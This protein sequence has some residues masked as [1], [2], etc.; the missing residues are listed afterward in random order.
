MEYI[1]L[2]ILVPKKDINLPD[3]DITVFPEV[4][5]E[6][7]D[8]HIDAGPPEV[9]GLDYDIDSWDDEAIDQL[10]RERWEEG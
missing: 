1:S 9:I 6:P 3:V 2:K 10:A 7:L 4:A 5:G 8:I